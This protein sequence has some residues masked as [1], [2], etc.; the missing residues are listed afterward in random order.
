M[1]HI[2]NLIN[3]ASL[4]VKR[5]E[6]KYNISLDPHVGDVINK[7]FTFFYSIC[8]GF[9]KQYQ[10]PKRLI[11]E[12]TQWVRA[13]MDERLDKLEKIQHGIKRC[14]LES[15]IN[16]PTI[17]QFIKW[18]TPTPESLGIPHLN[19]AYNEAC[20]N[21]SPYTTEKKWS[22]QAVYHAYSMCNSYDLVNLPKENTFPIFERNYDITVKMIMRGEPLKTIPIALT[23]NKN[24]ETKP[25]IPQEFKDCKDF[26]SAKEAMGRI[27]GVN[28]GPKRPTA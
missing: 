10:D 27:L 8:R 28:F 6:E 17:G 18:C 14:R 7:L 15:P 5:E 23:H 13:F 3:T 16:T 1:E 11:M 22:H 9:E 24:P 21:S 4:S 12:K 26:D 20:K 2:S 25:K 19:S